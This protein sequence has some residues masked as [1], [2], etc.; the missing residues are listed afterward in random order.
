MRNLVP[1]LNQRLI[2]QILNL[3]AKPLY[4]ACALPEGGPCERPDHNSRK[5]KD[6]NN[7]A[8]RPF[9]PQQ[10][11]DK[12]NQILDTLPKGKSGNQHRL[13]FVHR[14]YFCV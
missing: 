5:T 8:R 12:K 10:A 11:C 7:D 6:K 3:L 13:Y 14:R 2:A 9:I 1:T 4:R